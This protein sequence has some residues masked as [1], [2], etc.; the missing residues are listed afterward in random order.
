MNLASRVP[1]SSANVSGVLY[2]IAIPVQRSAFHLFG[3]PTEADP[4]CR[5]MTDAQEQMRVPG[6]PNFG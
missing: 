1:R 2:G 5:H 6:C 4:K 3:H